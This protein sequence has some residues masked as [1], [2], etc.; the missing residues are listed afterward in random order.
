[1]VGQVLDGDIAALRGQRTD[2]VEGMQG[3]RTFDDVAGTSVMRQTPCWQRKATVD[4]EFSGEWS[5]RR[6]VVC[7]LRELLVRRRH[8]GPV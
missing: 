8:P 5:V 6:E 7:L 3:T 1:M 4:T 2:R